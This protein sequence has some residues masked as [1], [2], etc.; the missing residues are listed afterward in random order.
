MTNPPNGA[1]AAPGKVHLDALDSLR[2]LSA[3]VVVFYHMNFNSFLYNLPLVRHGYLFVDFFFV[4]SG[5]IMYYNY[6]RIAGLGGFGRFMGM[7]FFRLYPLH[8]AMLMVFVVWNFFYAFVRGLETSATAPSTNDGW[9]DFA[10]NVLLLNGLGIRQPGFNSPSWSISVEFWTYL[11]FGLAVIA[12]SNARKSVMATVFVIISACSLLIMLRW[13]RPFHLGLVDAFSLPRCFYGFFLG[14]TLCAIFKQAKVF[15]DRKG[16]FFAVAAQIVAVTAATTVLTLLGVTAFDFL[17]PVLF[18]AVIAT[19]VIWPRTWLTRIAVSKPLLW[20]GKHSYSIYM[21]HFF[22]IGC[23]ETILRVALHVPF[24]HYRFE[25]SNTLGLGLAVGSATIVLLV[26]SQ[27]YRFIE[28]PGRDFGRRLL[29]R[30]SPRVPEAAT[31][32]SAAPVHE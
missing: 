7:R 21:V 14:S 10:L 9:L 1:P 3:L 5:F 32:A 15:G 24:S 8:L 27:T 26:A 20:L 11:L 22:V 2:G 29:K 12:G 25:T 6:D 28:E 31:E 30:R 13:V 18:A 23:V 4:L 19:F 16:T 17:L